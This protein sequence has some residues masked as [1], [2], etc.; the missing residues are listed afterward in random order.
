[1]NLGVE[2][3]YLPYSPNFRYSPIFRGLH[4]R[5]NPRL[6]IMFYTYPRSHTIL[7]TCH[8]GVIPGVEPLF[9]AE[10]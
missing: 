6:L 5:Y 10:T 8:T 4:P 7:Y 9:E 1:M 3:P 2:T